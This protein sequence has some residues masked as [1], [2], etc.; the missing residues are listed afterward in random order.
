MEKKIEI[1]PK[2]LYHFLICETRYGYTRNNHLM[3]SSA[4]DDCKALLPL[5]LL[6]DK[7]YALHTA[8][9]LCDECIFL[10]LTLTFGDGID[11]I[12]GNRKESIDFVYWLLDWINTNGDANYKPYNYDDFLRNVGIDDKPQYRVSE[13]YG[14]DLES[15]KWEDSKVITK[16]K[17]LSKNAYLKFIFDYVCGPS[18]GDG[19]FYN[20]INL[21]D[22]GCGVKKPTTFVYHLHTV[23]RRTFLVEIINRK[24]GAAK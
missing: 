22:D 18:K 23:P 8:K 4:F 2:D 10:N 24:E 15:N 6:A 3:P 7:E 9:Q 21:S 1:S 5:F 11:D 17:L 13:L 14:Y 20:I 12:H 16:G 19:F